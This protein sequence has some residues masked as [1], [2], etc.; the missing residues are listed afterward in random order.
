MFTFGQKRR[1][2][3]KV[4]SITQTT[5]EN[6]CCAWGKIEKATIEELEEVKAWSKLSKEKLIPIKELRWGLMA[7]LDSLENLEREKKLQL[8]IDTKHK[9]RMIKEKEEEE[10][11]LKQRPQLKENGWRK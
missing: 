7:K 2:D 6:P 11:M 1:H 10:S 8:E 4:R 9:M 5:T 3:L